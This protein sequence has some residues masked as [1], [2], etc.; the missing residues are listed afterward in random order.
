MQFKAVLFD[1]DGTLLN[2]LD[3]L[4]DAMNAVL[5]A[6]KFP[7]HEIDAYR[8]FIGNGF[9]PLVQRALPEKA[10]DDRTIAQCVAALREEYQ[11]RWTAK[12]APYPGIVE[13]LDACRAAGLRMVILSNKPDEATRAIVSRTLSGW[14]FEIVRG[15]VPGVPKK[16]DPFSAASIAAQMHL[17]P[18]DFVYLG[19]TDVDMQTATA[20]DM[21][22][23]G[24]LW[25]FR[26]PGE[27]LASGARMLINTPAD[28]L[29]WL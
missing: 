24:V 25:G 10:R 26:G 15:S 29:P 22:A 21:F 28:L 7:G 13:L 11:R 20:A 8:N 27:L 3:D 17:V 5:T 2:T 16:P 4:A 12:T 14:P 1:L 6:R 18:R 9:E 19:D 23:I